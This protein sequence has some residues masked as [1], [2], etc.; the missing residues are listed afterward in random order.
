MRITAMRTGWVAGLALL[1]LTLPQAEAQYFRFGKNRV[2]YHTPTWYYIQSRHFDIYYYE[3]GYE[4]A[5]FTAE[6]AEAAYAELVSLL[7]YEL[8]QRIA[9]LVYPSHN[10]FSVTN[11]VDLPDYSE[12]IGGVTELFKNRIAVPFMGDY[13]DYRRVVHHELVHAVL[14]D[15]FYGGSLQAIL[16]NNL[17][18]VLPLWFNEGLAEYAALGWDAQS[19]M[20]VR[21]AILNDRLAPIPYLS[22][23]FAYRGGQSVWDYIATQYGRE[24]I[25][26]ILQRVRLTHSVETGFRQATGLSLAEL[27]ERWQQA[28][29]EIYYPELTAREQLDDIGRP[30]L[31]ARNA[32]YYN[33]SP[34]LTPQGDRLA[35]I[36][37]RNG[38]FDVYLASATDGKILRRLVAGQTS[39]DFE[40]LRILTPGLSWSPDGRFLALAVKSGPSDAI[41]I[42][43]VETGRKTHHRI[44]GVEQI[45]SLAWSPDGRCIAFS[46]TSK[47]QSDIYVL[48]LHTGQVINY[49]NDVFSDH[50]PAWRPDGKALVFHSDRGDQLTPGQQPSNPH[51]LMAQVERG[52]D[53]YLLHL[54]PVRLERLTH[55]ERWDERSGRF[56]S[57]PNRLLFISDRNGIP[58]LYEKDLRTGAERPLTDLVVGIQQLSLSA[59]G[60]KAAVVSL[61]EGIPS[62]YLIKD[63]FERKGERDTLAPTVWAQRKLRQATPPAPALAVASA[64]LRQRNPFLRAANTPLPT[65]PLPAQETLMATTDQH[66]SG[67]AASA[68]DSLTAYSLSRVDFRNYVF[69][70]AFDEAS[71]RHRG[72]RTVTDPF[73]PENNRDENGRYQPRRYRLY[74]T[75]DLVYGA[76]GY[77]MLYGVQSVTEILFSDMLGNHRFWVATNLLV[78]LRNSDYVIAYSYLPRRTDWTVA[79]YHIARLLPDYTLRTLYRYRHYGLNLEASYPFNK[80]ERFDLDVALMGVNQTDIGNPERPPLTRSLLYPAITYT[81]DVSVPGLLAPIGGHR[82]AVQLSGSP[83]NLVAGRQIQF[84][85]LLADARTYTSFGRGLYSLAVRLAGGASFGPTPQLFYSAGVQNWINRHF[86]SFPIEDLTDFVFATPVLPL[87]ATAIN[88]LN[89][90]YFGLLNAEFRFP[91]IAALLPG[92]L[93]VLP[94]YNLQGTAFLDVGT[95]WGSPSNRRLTFF[96]RTT[97]GQQVLDDLRVATGI[98][99]RTILLGFPLRFDFAWPFDG[100]RFGNRH[101]YLSVGLDF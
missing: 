31:T 81:R 8:S 24:K 6:A 17:Q 82:L 55:H 59:D 72:Y 93:P 80:F 37:T 12:G 39:P 75:P 9:I 45:L 5:T 18:L 66:A 47:A 50:E 30:L 26:E 56:G 98:G 1:L 10:A 48:D 83:G 28:L 95:V 33:T 4:L 38:L 88:T 63:P 21:E 74:F 70:S 32:G 73:T 23:Y 15:M 40:S 69:S 35:F 87:R 85:T 27:S 60:R 20:Y 19:D 2:H 13:R 53:L 58:N 71:H 99:L 46:A 11:A 22:G 44:P 96:R 62:I 68:T 57:D 91:L 51:A 43:D 14:N 52:Y 54:D 101:F 36:T 94:L 84:L 100:R 29:R 90:P 92:P 64:T 77:D 61:R 34:A 78:D 67:N 41:A 76:A 42:L 97:E 79:V 89:G 49:T 86:D 16:Q 25:A 3:G 65:F 7:Q